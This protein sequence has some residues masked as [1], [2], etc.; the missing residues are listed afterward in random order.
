VSGLLLH[1][2][3]DAEVEQLEEG[4]VGWEVAAVAGDLAELVVERLDRSG[5][6]T[7][8]SILEKLVDSARCRWV[9]WRIGSRCPAPRCLSICGC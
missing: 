5:S 1:D 9:C 2:V 3:A 8:R 4:V 7:R 6:G